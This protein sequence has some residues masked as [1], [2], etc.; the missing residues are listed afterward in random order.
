MLV[1]S[2]FAH[3]AQKAITDEGEVVILNDDGTWTREDQT[4]TVPVE[5]ALN[6]KI[7]AKGAEASFQLKSKK[8]KAAFWIDTQQWSFAKAASNAQAEYEFQLKGKDLYAMAITEEIPIDVENLAQL[9]L[10]NAKSAAPNA[11][12]KIQEYRVVNGTKVLYMEIAGTVQGIKFVYLGHYFSD[13]N[14]STQFM[15][16]TSENLVDKYRKDIERFLNGF[17][18]QP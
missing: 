2:L 9:A 5:I 13:Q 8:N 14:G 4:A 11:K 17:S 18:T 3:A 6:K 15:A 1:S 7:F 10:Q 16:Y 12:I